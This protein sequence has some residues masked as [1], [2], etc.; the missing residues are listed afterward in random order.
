[1]GNRVARSG[2]Q[3]EFRH[4][5]AELGCGAFGSSSGSVSARLLLR[6]P[7]DRSADRPPMQRALLTRTQRCRSVVL[8]EP[9]WSTWPGEAEGDRMLLL[10]AALEHLLR[11]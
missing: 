6:T 1:M 11:W 10:C 7:A 9:D 3:T 4:G 2:R 5:D 8:E